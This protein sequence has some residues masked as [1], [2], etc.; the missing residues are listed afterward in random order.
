MRMAKT[1][2]MQ[3]VAE[4]ALT[5]LWCAAGAEREELKNG[6]YYTVEQ[7]RDWNALANDEDVAKRLWEWTEQELA[8]A[9]L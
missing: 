3:D 1:I 6:A 8:R 7:A 4:G 5:Q 9:G 2:I